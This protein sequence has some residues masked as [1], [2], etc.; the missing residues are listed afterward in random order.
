[1]GGHTLR[2]WF[3][4][5]F[6]AGVDEKERKGVD[7]LRKAVF[8]TGRAVGRIAFRIDGIKRCLSIGMAMVLGGEAA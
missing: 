6:C 3:S 8:A 7:G 4:V 5:A 2:T 1:M